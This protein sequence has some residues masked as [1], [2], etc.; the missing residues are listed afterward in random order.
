[1]LITTHSINNHSKRTASSVLNQPA[2]I[3][4]AEAGLQKLDTFL[5]QPVVKT[6]GMG[7]AST[8]PV[9]G[10][11]TNATT[12]IEGD[13]DQ[14]YPT[15]SKVAKGAAMTGSMA[16]MGGIISLMFATSGTPGALPVGIGLLALSG[17]TSA[18]ATYVNA[19]GQAA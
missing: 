5:K 19:N 11:M 2:N 16:N 6:I 18:F 14:R 15:V 10:M 9:V 13:F 12:G 1:M 17:A 7:L 8:I 4:K 3:E